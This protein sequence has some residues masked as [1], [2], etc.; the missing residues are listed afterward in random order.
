MRAKQ[1][2]GGGVWPALWMLGNNNSEVGWPACGEIDIMEYAGNRVNK[3][4]A[5]LHHPGHSGGNPDGGFNMITNAETEFH[6]YTLEWTLDEIKIFVDNQQFFVFANSSKVPF[7]HDFF[8]LFNCAV[9]GTY[10]G[11]ID[12]NFTASNFDID[13]V[14]VYQ[15]K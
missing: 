9:G 8:L 7:N 1:P 13:Y 2:S 3:V 6:I 14:R 15:N 12:P 5:A 11:A 10:G 4:T